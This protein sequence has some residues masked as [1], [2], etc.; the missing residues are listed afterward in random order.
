VQTNANEVMAMVVAVDDAIATVQMGDDHDE[1]VFPRT[2][3][4]HD[5]V[6]GSTLV[7]DGVGNDAQVLDHHLPSPGIE[8]RLGR[9]LN[10]RRLALD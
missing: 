1:W 7:F 5:L 3:L 2:M 10:R 6:V 9:S 8:D 4:P